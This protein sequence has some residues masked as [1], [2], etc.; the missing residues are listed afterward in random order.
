MP[1]KVSEEEKETPAA[2]TGAKSVKGDVL[3]I[4]CYLFTWLSGLIL[5]LTEGKTNKE[6]RFHALQAI[7]VGLAMIVCWFFFWLLFIPV[8]IAIALWIYGLYVGYVAYSTG[9]RKLIP[10]IGEYALKYAEKE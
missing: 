1:K 10:V 5:Y 3:Y 4:V 8:L 7:G 6:M 2:P 9:E